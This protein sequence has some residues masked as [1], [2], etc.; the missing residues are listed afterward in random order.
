MSKKEEKL[1]EAILTAFI[2]TTLEKEAFPLS[3]FKFSKENNIEEK[4]FYKHFGSLDAVKGQIWQFFYDNAMGLLEKDATFENASPKD[5]LL[6]FYFTFFEV[7]LL[8]R[9]YVLFS[10][11]SH[12]SNMVKMS[13]L[14]KMRI[15][16]KDFAKDLINTGNTNKNE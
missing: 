1:K 12:Q 7:L 16:F 8:N 14:S 4:T 13:Q 10:L 2:D 6:S 11:F 9:S 3:V 15:S 5:K